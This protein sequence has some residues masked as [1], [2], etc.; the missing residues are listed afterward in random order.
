MLSLYVILVANSMQKYMSCK[1]ACLTSIG[2]DQP[3]EIVDDAPKDLI[4]KLEKLVTRIS[5][6]IVLVELLTRKEHRMSTIAEGFANSNSK[7]VEWIS[8][9]SRGQ[10]CWKC[11]KQ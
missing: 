8:N 3:A 6:G 2:A 9:L 5:F 7:L 10:Q 1:G 11:T 4:S